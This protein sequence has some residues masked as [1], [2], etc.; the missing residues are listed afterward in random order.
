MKMIKNW[1]QTALSRRGFISFL[2]LAVYHFIFKSAAWARAEY[3]RVKEFPIRSIEKTPKVDLKTWRLKVEGLVD[4]PVSFGFDEIKALPKKVQNKSFICVEGWG[5]D[6]QIWEGV[7]LKDVF[8][9]VVISSKAKFVTFIAV[10][11]Y[12]RDSL[13]IKEALEPDTMAAYKVNEK[14][15]APENGFPLRLIIPR[16]Y[17]YKGVKWME[18]IVFTEEQE[19]GYWEQSGYSVDG[20]IPGIKN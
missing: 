8:S 14:D 11:G 3:I 18:R 12:Y 7:H 15:L 2:C 13:S 19:E 10:G 9:K 1:I 17:A 16:M 20:S 6:N 4:R 5:L